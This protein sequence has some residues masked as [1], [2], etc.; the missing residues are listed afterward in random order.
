MPRCALRGSGVEQ[1]CLD[2]RIP[3]P[4]LRRP[5]WRQT[6]RFRNDALHSLGHGL[7][8]PSAFLVAF[9]LTRL[10]R[11]HGGR[12][13]RRSPCHEWHL[14]CAGV[15]RRVLSGQGT[16]RCEK[17]PGVYSVIA[18]DKREAFA[19]GS[20]ATK[21]SMLPWRRYGLLRFA[22][23]DEFTRQPCPSWSAGPRHS[24]STVPCRRRFRW[25]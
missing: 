7:S 13:A 5:R 25:R 2:Q 16:L 20:E 17:S 9:P 18:Y 23:N 12:Q 21:Q 14:C 22:R 8:I 3:D 4:R 6:L 19:Q 11:G 10:G 1:P 24:R 15:W